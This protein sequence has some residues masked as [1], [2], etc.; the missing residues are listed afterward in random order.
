MAGEA[1]SDVVAL[2]DTRERIIARL[3]EAFASG[4]LEMDEFERRITLAHRTDSAGMLEDLVK[5]LAATPLEANAALV[6]ASPAVAALAHVAPSAEESAFSILGSIHR[7]G[8]WTPPRVLRVLSVMGQVELD[9]REAIFAS[10]VSEVIVNT[11]MGQ[12]DIIVPPMLAVEMH[13]ST[14]MGSFEHTQRSPVMAD[15][16]RPLLRV[17]GV[18]VMGA[19]TIKTRLPGESG[20]DAFMRR[21]RER[22]ALREGARTP[23]LPSGKR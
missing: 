16:D 23:L 6:T 11:I 3:S 19:V 7:A 2:R 13:G 14:I 10:G 8:A 1:P 5:D 9:F 18:A 22:K 17:H 12:V 21:R 4:A 20:F 15:P